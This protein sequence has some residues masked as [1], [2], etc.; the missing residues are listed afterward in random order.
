[1]QI[2]QVELDQGV[3]VMWQ[4]FDKQLRVAWDPQQITSAQF[5]ALRL[6]VLTKEAGR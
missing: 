1:M 4:R 6:G 2:E 5:E 3:P